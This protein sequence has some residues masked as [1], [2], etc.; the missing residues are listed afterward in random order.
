MLKFNHTQFIFY[1]WVQ[2]EEEKAVCYERSAIDPIQRL[3]HNSISTMH[4][5]S[6]RIKRNF[7]I[8][9]KT[10]VCLR[11][12]FLIRLQAHTLVCFHWP[13]Q[14]LLLFGS[15]LFSVLP[16]CVW[17]RLY[18][19]HFFS[20]LYYQAIT[21]QNHSWKVSMCIEINIKGFVVYSVSLFNAMLNL[22]FFK[23]T[24]FRSIVFNCQKWNLDMF[25]GK[26][27]SVSSV[28]SLK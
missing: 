20:V 18:Y 24:Q 25:K 27:L 9:T 7:L 11:T 4:D 8:K 3:T 5:T 16:P 23:V 14:V 1:W 19:M 6:A 17:Q 13:S 12:F 22:D 2:E 28:I 21:S 10:P 26:Y 15:V